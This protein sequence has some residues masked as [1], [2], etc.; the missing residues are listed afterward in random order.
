MLGLLRLGDDPLKLKLA[1]TGGLILSCPAFGQVTHDA[2][3]GQ[4]ALQCP[5]SGSPN[6]TVSASV[7]TGSQIVTPASMAGIANGAYLDFDPASQTPQTVSGEAIATGDGSTK[8]FGG[9]STGLAHASLIQG[10][11]AIKVSGTAVAT[12]Q[13]GRIFGS[14]VDGTIRWLDGWYYIV[15]ATAPGSGLAFEP[16]LAQSSITQTVTLSGTGVALGIAPVSIIFG[17]V[18]E[19][20]QSA[21][22]TVTLTNPL[23]TALAFTA[24]VTPSAY[25]VS[26]GCGGSIPA[27]GTCTL[28]VSFDPQTTGTIAG[29]LTVTLN[30]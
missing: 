8:I 12:D 5:L 22:Q 25:S 4:A 16:A 13:N 1:I 21:A 10:T 23:S 11:L 24:T 14:G 28:S 20:Q 3:G 29:A 9:P 18:L 7:S 27:N 19:G 15:F 2:W 30:P 17:N 26:N 6:T